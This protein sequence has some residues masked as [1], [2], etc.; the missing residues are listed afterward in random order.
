MV[1]TFYLLILHSVIYFVHCA[2]SLIILFYICACCDTLCFKI[3]CFFLF[4]EVK[5]LLGLCYMLYYNRHKIKFLCL[6][7]LT[8]K[9]LASFLWDIGKH[10]STWSDATERGV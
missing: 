5:A 7:L 9:R 4:V 2:L 1:Y 6:C 8:I 10:C 3:V